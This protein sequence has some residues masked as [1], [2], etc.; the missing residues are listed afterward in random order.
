VGAS[1]IKETQLSNEQKVALGK[2]M[3]QQ[4]VKNEIKKKNTMSR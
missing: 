2:Q 4:A 1:S 3:L